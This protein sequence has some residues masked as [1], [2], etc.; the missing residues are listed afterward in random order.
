MKRRR[1]RFRL[2]TINALGH[3]HT[4]PGGNKAGHGWLQSTQRTILLVAVITKRRLGIV[5]LQEFQSTQQR[6]FRSRASL[7]RSHDYKDNAV[8]WLRARWKLVTAGH[9]Y[10]PYFHGT[11]KPMPWVVLRRR[12]PLK[13]RR[14]LIAVLSTHNPANVRGPAERWRRGGWANEAGWAR[15]MVIDGVV[16][17]AFVVGD[18]NAPA[19]IYKP[20]VEKRGGIV[21][22]IPASD[23]PNT[24]GKGIDWI[25]G[26]GDVRFSRY[27]SAKTRRIARMTDHPVEQ[28]VAAIRPARRTADRKRH[29]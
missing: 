28:V 20:F 26:W 10:I 13:R 4:R 8:V 6:V 25:V 9:L 11:E 16:A 5:G 23:L 21:A 1:V 12:S 7:W 2:A 24:P 27:R 19:A 18:K 29:R 3:S 14:V 15:D 17:A 22:G